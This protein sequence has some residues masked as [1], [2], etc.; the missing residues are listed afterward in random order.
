VDKTL[1]AQGAG[2]SEA[3][4]RVLSSLDVRSENKSGMVDQPFGTI[5]AAMDNEVQIRSGQTVRQERKT[6]VSDSTPPTSG[7]SGNAEGFGSTIASSQTLK[8]EYKTIIT[9]KQF[10]TGALSLLAGSRLRTVEAPKE[11]V[12]ETIPFK[13]YLPPAGLGV[14]TEQSSG[15]TGMRGAPIHH[16]GHRDKQQL[17]IPSLSRV[18]E[19]VG[20]TEYRIIPEQ[21]GPPK[22]KLGATMAPRNQFYD[23]GV[24]TELW[25]VRETQRSKDQNP[26]FPDDPTSQTL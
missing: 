7:V 21:H 11:T 9:D 26:A 2:M 3:G 19:G 25:D 10:P 14:A 6:I 17:Y 24:R 15:Q 5:G 16:L 13:F 23:S 22:P 1:P 12:R 4:A 8:N 18:S 20:G